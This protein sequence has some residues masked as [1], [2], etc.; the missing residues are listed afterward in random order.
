M[1]CPDVSWLLECSSFGCCV[2]HLKWLLSSHTTAKV[3]WNAAG[4]TIFARKLWSSIRVIGFLVSCL[5]NAL[6]AHLLTLAIAA[7]LK[8]IIVFLLLLHSYA[9]NAPE[10][11]NSFSNFFHSSMDFYLIRILPRTSPES[12]LDLQAYRSYLFWYWMYCDLWDFV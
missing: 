11:V 6:F 5:T 1:V 2:L 9:H 4:S 3:W 12:S 10:S 8:R 7:G